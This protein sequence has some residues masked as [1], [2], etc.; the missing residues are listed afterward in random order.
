MMGRYVVSRASHERSLRPA[1]ALPQQPLAS[2][3]QR[4][5]RL[6]ALLAGQPWCEALSYEQWLLAPHLSSLGDAWRR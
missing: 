4:L 2:Q 5:A 3:R 1:P 6:L